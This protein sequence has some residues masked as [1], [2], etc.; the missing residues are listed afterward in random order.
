MRDRQKMHE[1]QRRWYQRVAK[2]RRIAW[3]KSNGPCVKCG[4]CKNLEVDH[5]D[6]TTKVDH[7][8]WTWREDRREAELAKCQVLC[9]ECHREKSSAE[10]SKL[11]KGKPNT[12]Q[13]ILKPQ[14]VREIR[15]LA[16]EGW[17]NGELA[18]YFGVGRTTICD[19]RTGLS[20]AGIK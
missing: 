11:N 18:T 19:V 5:R 2:A 1:A 9:H 14:D 4:S 10:S 17:S 13:R 7:N 20:Y 8:L 3:L 6:P 16:D 12:W 15:K